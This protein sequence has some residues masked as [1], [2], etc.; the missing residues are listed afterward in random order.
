MRYNIII[1]YTS[2]VLE[3]MNIL[4]SLMLSNILLNSIKEFEKITSKGKNE[5]FD[6]TEKS[7][8]SHT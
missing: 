2:Q 6:Q 5:K 3:F 4:L 1:D 7:H 8:F